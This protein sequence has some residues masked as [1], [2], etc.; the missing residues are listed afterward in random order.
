M[1]ELPVTQGILDVVI[2]HAHMNR[3][4]KVHAISLAIGEMSDLQ[5]EWIQ[6]YFDYISKGTIAEGARLVI[7]RVTVVF[8]CK[9]CSEDFQVDIRKMKEIVCPGCGK[10]DFELV[11]GR[12]YYIRNMEAE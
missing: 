1:H 10:N 9:G 6:R 7:E 11:S 3:V 5:D 4:T 12:E 2:R 8:R